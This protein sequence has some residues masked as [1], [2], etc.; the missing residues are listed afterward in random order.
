MKKAS[1]AAAFG[2]FMVLFAFAADAGESAADPGAVAL[3]ARVP[4]FLVHNATVLDGI[5]ELSSKRPELS[6]A[7]EEVLKTKFNDPEPPQQRFDLSLENQTASEI[8]DA[9]CSSDARYAWI[10]DGLTVN[11]YPRSTSNDNSYFPNRQITQL[12]LQQVTSTDQAVFAV[13]G[14]LPRPFEQIA[15]AQLGGDTTYATA[16]TATFR[17]ISVRQA[18]NLIALRLGPGGGWVFGGSREF[19]TIGFHKGPFT[20]AREVASGAVIYTNDGPN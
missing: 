2:C 4:R 8:L 9:L 16:W 10:R 1:I 7:F 13:A 11:V 5:A 17:N 6:Y 20:V 12:E 18:L 3:V 19:R 15:L 14:Q